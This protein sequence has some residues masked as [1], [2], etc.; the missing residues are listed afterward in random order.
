MHE[1]W[2]EY[3]ASF[4]A[5]RHFLRPY[6]SAVLFLDWPAVGHYRLLV[7]LPGPLGRGPSLT[8]TAI[9]RAH[10][11]QAGHG[12]RRLAEAAVVVPGLVPAGQ[13]RHA[14]VLRESPTVAAAG[15]P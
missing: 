2:A 4:G 15:S 3:Q 14:D 10:N 13:P 12:P 5:A 1:A 9:L 6:R 7:G 8:G 11:T